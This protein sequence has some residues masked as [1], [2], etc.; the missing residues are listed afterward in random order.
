[1]ENGNAAM[2]IEALIN[3]AT[4]GHAVAVVNGREIISHTA[5][6]ETHIGNI[7]CNIVKRQGR[8]I[9]GRTLKPQAILTLNGKRFRRAYIEAR[10]EGRI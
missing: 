8:A 2:T 6:V 5:S 7:G 10:L 4:A 1:M 9:Q 3:E